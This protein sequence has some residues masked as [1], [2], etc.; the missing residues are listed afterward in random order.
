MKQR[1]K[2]SKA[3]AATCVLVRSACLLGQST[4]A[5]LTLANG[6]AQPIE[7]SQPIITL[8]HRMASGDRRVLDEFWSK[9]ARI[10]TPLVE[11]SKN[12]TGWVTV[13]FVWRGDTR[14]QN[15]ALRSSTSNAVSHNSASTISVT[16]SWS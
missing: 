5:T 9:A 8:E 16:L 6:I 15:V 13:T 4:P 7:A 3:L 12:D 11:A 14:T 1:I 10:G 2:L